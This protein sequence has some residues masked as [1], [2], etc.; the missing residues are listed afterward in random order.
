MDRLPEVARRGPTE[1]L[2]LGRATPREMLRS[3]EWSSSVATATS[4]QIEA[5]EQRRSCC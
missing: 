4:I 5:P 2:G 3:A 1:L